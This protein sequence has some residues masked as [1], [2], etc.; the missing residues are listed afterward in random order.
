MLLDSKVNIKLAKKCYQF[1]K[2]IAW[3][4]PVLTSENWYFVNLQELQN[5][6][7]K[8]KGVL[9]VSVRAFHW[10]SDLHLSFYIITGMAQ[11]LTD[12]PT[13]SKQQMVEMAKMHVFVYFP[14]GNLWISLDIL[15]KLRHRLKAELEWLN[16]FDH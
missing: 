10:R 7:T 1:L 8:K 2:I 9:K 13:G 5:F 4:F 16:S 14:L 6:L 12:F 11:I 3:W 15:L